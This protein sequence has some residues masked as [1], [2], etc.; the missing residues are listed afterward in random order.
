MK[1][2]PQGPKIGKW[3]V[4]RGGS[5]YDNYRYCRVTFRGD[6]DASHMGDDLGF[7]VCMSVKVKVKV[8]A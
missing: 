2:N 1:T 6:C 7:R 3:R 5:W 4:N 8:K